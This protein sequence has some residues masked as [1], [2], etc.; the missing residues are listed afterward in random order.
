[1]KCALQTIGHRIAALV[2]R[3][4]S[5]PEPRVRRSFARLVMSSAASGSKGS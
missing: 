2:H 4:N 5:A 1:V 3:A